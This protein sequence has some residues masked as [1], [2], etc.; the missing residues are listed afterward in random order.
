MQANDILDYC[1]KNLNGT[2][3]ANN[4][5]EQGIFYN[6]NHSLPKGVYILTVK[7]K[8]GANDKASYRFSLP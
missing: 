8:D 3:L 5:G 1:L 7:E 2:V 6:P 4:C